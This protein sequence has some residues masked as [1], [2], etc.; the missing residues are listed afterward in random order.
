ME[1]LLTI[2][3]FVVFLLA[4]AWAVIGFLDWRSERIRSKKWKGVAIRLAARYPRNVVTYSSRGAM[5]YV[6]ENRINI[7]DEEDTIDYGYIDA[8]IRAYLPRELDWHKV[9]WQKEGF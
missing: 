7:F 1:N 6:V 2:L 4:L 5:I 3:L 8:C 9:N